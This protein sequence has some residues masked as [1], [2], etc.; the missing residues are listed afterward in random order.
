VEAASREAFSPPGKWGRGTG[1]L[2]AGLGLIEL[3]LRYG[4][5]NLH[6]FV[7]EKKAQRKRGIFNLKYSIKS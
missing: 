6:T 2:W 5:N 4:V 7:I 1:G 3:S